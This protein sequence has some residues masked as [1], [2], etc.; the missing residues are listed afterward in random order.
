MKK[1]NNIVMVLTGSLL[2]G[3]MM[4]SAA[5]KNAPAKSLDEQ[6][7]HELV[8]LPFYNVFDNLTYSVNGD[9]VTIG[10]QV[11]R[12]TL[13]SSAENVVKALP[14][15]AKVHNNIEVLPLSPFDNR[16]RLAVYRSIYTQPGLDR[17]AL[18]AVPG[19]HI[20]VKNGNVT[21][22]GVVNN[23]M[24]RNMAFLRANGVSGVFHVE[25]NL[26]VA[27]REK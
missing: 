20:V 3:S 6:V 5:T 1:I 27:S 8:M 15:V 12:P 26:R 24:E 11:T 9:E 21:L 7:R 19:I 14:G 17:Y 13:R 16:L 23:D 10:G 25:N 2:A 22:E 4:L 18:G